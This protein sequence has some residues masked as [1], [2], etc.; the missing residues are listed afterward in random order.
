M[1]QD[2]VG[3]LKFVVDTGR[4]PVAATTGASG[5]IDHQGH[6]EEHRVLLHDFRGIQ[7]E[8]DGAGFCCVCHPTAVAD[9]HDPADRLWTVR[10]NPETPPRP[11]WRYADDTREAYDGSVGQPHPASQAEGS[12]Q[13]TD[14]NGRGSVR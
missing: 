1:A 11:R 14:K 10:A 3:R 9:F 4:M 6:F 8:L 13:G 2:I 5:Q 7:T 12:H